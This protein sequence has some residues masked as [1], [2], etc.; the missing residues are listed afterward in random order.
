MFSSAHRLGAGIPGADAAL[1]RFSRRPSAPTFSRDGRDLAKSVASEPSAAGNSFAQQLGETLAGYLN[2]TSDGSSLE[3]SITPQGSQ[4][5]GTRQFVVTVKDPAAASAP[6]PETAA[7]AT[8]AAAAASAT[9][10]PAANLV[11]YGAMSPFEY[12]SAY[13]AANPSAVEPPKAATAS[14][15]PANETDAYW[16]MFPQEVQALRTIPNRDERIQ[17]A[18]GLVQQG[19]TVDAEIMVLGND[20]YGTM[21]MRRDLGYT[22]TP[23]MGQ[24]PIAVLPGLQ[25]PGRAS[26]DP[27]NPPPGSIPVS[28]DFA[29]GLEMTSPLMKKYEVTS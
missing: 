26:Y 10:T 3:I 21:L 1:D 25:Y 19:F 6:T 12:G 14:D 27:G 2:Q 22:W 13:A 4:T 8:A 16:S 7:T 17:A 5:S 23:A 28:L 18:W 9:A 20:P 11:N 29:K 15:A 24:P